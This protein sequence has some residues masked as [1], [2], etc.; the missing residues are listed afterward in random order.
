MKLQEIKTIE[1]KGISIAIKIDYRRGTASLVE[2]H[3]NKTWRF[4]DRGLE[5]MNSWLTILDAMQVAV[6]ECKKILEADLAEKARL[7][8]DLIV[9]A[10]L[11]E[12]ER[13][14]K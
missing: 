12:G 6:T 3:S 13:K 10:L 11:A 1:H 14:K 2:E 8:E 7:K 5:Y 9:G 4:V